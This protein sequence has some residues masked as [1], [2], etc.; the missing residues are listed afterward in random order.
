MLAS[1]HGAAHPV[2]RGLQIGNPFRATSAHAYDDGT[3]LVVTGCAE[4]A[5]VGCAEP[6]SQDAMSVALDGLHWDVTANPKVPLIPEED[7]L[8][9]DTFRLGLPAPAELQEI[10]LAIDDQHVASAFPPMFAF[11][12][13]PS[14]VS[15]GAGPIAIDHDVLPNAIGRAIVVTTCGAATSQLTFNDDPR[16]HVSI[17]LSFAGQG[18]CTHDIRL[19][20]TVDLPAEATSISGSLARIEVVQVSS[21]P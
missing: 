5:V 11:T 6:G 13:P 3:R 15:R 1:W 12:Q 14:R 2:A 10:E 21:D 7:A 16:G 19:S 9:V 18:S 8:Y 20:Q 4:N 17:D